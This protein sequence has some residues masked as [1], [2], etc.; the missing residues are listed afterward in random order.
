MWLGEAF[1]LRHH[2][3]LKI[4]VELNKICLNNVIT[5]HGKHLHADADGIR[6]SDNHFVSSVSISV[7]Y[8]LQ[9]IAGVLSEA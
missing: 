8:T 2:D 5:H 7:H 3:P 9:P 6:T 1:H 4:I